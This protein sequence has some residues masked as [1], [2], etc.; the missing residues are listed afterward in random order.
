MGINPPFTINVP[1]LKYPEP[2]FIT[3]LPKGKRR[4]A[5]KHIEDV[6]R[7]EN[8]PFPF[9]VARRALRIG[10]RDYPRGA[11]IDDAT[12]ATCANAQAWITGGYIVR[13]PAHVA[14]ANPPRP[15]IA[16]VEIKPTDH[17]AILRAALNVELDKRNISKP[18]FL[19]SAED[20]VASDIL[21]RGLQAYGDAP[22]LV[23]EIAWGAG[24]EVQLRVSGLGAT[25]VP[26]RSVTGFWEFIESDRTLADLKKEVEEYLGRAIAALTAITR[27]TTAVPIYWAPT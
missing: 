20:W 9:R 23:R 10:D 2:L 12:L 25:N 4:M 19:K 7:T 8:V 22:K 15:A 14:R 24:G 1:L 17:I 3:D 21:R 16:P 5:R 11:I 27:M 6:E 26:S 13:M 18:R